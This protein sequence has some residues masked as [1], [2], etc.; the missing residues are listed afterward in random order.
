MTIISDP[1]NRRV[2]FEIEQ[3]ANKTDAAVQ[4]GLSNSGKMLTKTLIKKINTGTRSGPR[5]PG[6]R[7]KAS[8]PGE[9][10]ASQTGRLSKSI[11]FKVESPRKL[12]FGSRV[13]HSKYLEFGTRRNKGPRKLIE[14]T[15]KKNSNKI[16]DQLRNSIESELK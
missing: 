12:V 10:P 8:R 15:V 11:G 1:K 2:F 9:Y 3:L 14:F 4:R 16:Y 5:Y 6:T 13:N 7:R